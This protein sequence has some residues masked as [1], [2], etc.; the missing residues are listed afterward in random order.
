[1]KRDYLKY[2]L[3]LV[4]FGSNGVVASHIGMS[5]YEIVF[6]RS[7]LGGAALLG[8]FL[9][10]GRQ[11]TLARHRRDA[12]MVALSGVA[13]GG[14]WLLLF[15]AYAQIGVSMGM[16]INYCGPAV[17]VALSPLVFRE[18]ITGRKAAAL[19]LALVGVCLISG[20][21]AAE[22]SRPWGILCA[23]LS[24]LCYAAMV[25]CNKKGGGITGL[26]NAL[27]QLL[28]AF[29]TVAVFT[30]LKGGFSLAV[31]AGQWPYILWLGLLNTGAGCYF[32]FSSLGRLPVQTVAVCGYLEPLSAVVLSALFLGERMG[33]VQL[34]GAVC[35]IGG[36]LYG[37]GPFRRRASPPS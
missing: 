37:E 13:M 19:V 9:A 3:A 20:Q 2:F 32:Y 5:S 18:R 4:L 7:L 31:P 26:E 23:A 34:A 30:A 8:L 15:E 1:M 21:A 22:G 28:S 25:I 24:A 10:A 14:D 12:F 27:L 11:F 17:V 29:V 36:A 6:W 16:V 33:P 35:I